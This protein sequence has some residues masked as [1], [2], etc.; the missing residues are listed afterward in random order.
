METKLPFLNRLRLRL[1]GAIY[2]PD[3]FLSMLGYSANLKV[4]RYEQTRLN[5]I[6]T[7]KLHRA[8]VAQEIMLS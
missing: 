6:L 1:Q 7:D 4:I 2:R 5:R 3:A 8:I